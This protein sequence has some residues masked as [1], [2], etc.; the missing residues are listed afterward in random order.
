LQQQLV[1]ERPLDVERRADL[2]GI[3][4]SLGTALNELGRAD[5]AIA[6]LEA[7]RGLY[8]ALGDGSPG[9]TRFRVEWGGT[10]RAL[11]HAYEG[12][13]RP[14]DSAAAW[15]RARGELTRAIEEKPEDPQRW[16]D[17]ALF[18]IRRRQ[19][20]L[21]ASDLR[22]AWSLDPGAAAWSRPVLWAALVLFGGDRE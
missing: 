6:P 9:K 10:L 20:S 21:A 17:R 12:A 14:V 1:A 13:N 18:Y 16:I 15:D 2:A 3:Q 8:E 19:E 11:G 7:A 5:E 4:L 22:R